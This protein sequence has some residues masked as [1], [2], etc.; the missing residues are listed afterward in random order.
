[1]PKIIAFEAGLDI[2]SGYYN[3]KIFM[4]MGYCTLDKYARA[5]RKSKLKFNEQ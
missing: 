2:G 1:M 5:V 3:T 4:D